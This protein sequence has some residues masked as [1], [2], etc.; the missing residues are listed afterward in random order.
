ME[1]RIAQ[2]IRSGSDE[3]LD[4]LLQ[5]FG[6]EIQGVAYLIVR[7]RADAEDI[8][9]ET[10]IT[11]WQRGKSLRD[12]AALRAWLLRIATNKALS[13]RRSN[14]RSVRLVE[15]MDIRSADPT[16]PLASRL[17]LAAAVGE[18]PPEMRAAVALHYFADLRVEDVAAT[19]GKSTNTIKS[20]LRVVL[21]RLRESLAER[22]E[23]SNGDAA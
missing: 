23:G 1:T 12:P 4:A 10:I 7:D 22:P 2:L 14:A 20:Q 16:G 19:L 13:R 5:Q 15:G 8:M 6:S 9:A 11:A 17:A 3:A 21:R 18:L